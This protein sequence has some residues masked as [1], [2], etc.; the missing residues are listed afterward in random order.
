M[1]GTTIKGSLW[2]VINKIWECYFGILGG[3][4]IL[5][6]KSWLLK[7]FGLV[8]LRSYNPVRWH[9]LHL[10]RMISNGSLVR[11]L[12]FHMI[13]MYLLQL[14]FK[15]FLEILALLL[16]HFKLRIQLPRVWTLI[17]AFHDTSPLVWIFIGVILTHRQCF[18]DRVHSFLFVNDTSSLTLGRLAIDR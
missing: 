10:L 16:N 4:L 8:R 14:Y 17:S 18:K 7:L 11:I 13:L 1:E 3:I 2:C 15:V 5:N 6:L 12:L 9:I